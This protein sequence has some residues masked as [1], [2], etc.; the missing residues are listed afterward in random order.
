MLFRAQ[1]GNHTYNLSIQETEAEGTLRVHDQPEEH[2]EF[3][4]CQ[5]DSMI[6]CLNN[7]I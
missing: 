1:Y 5:D 4:I 2:K 6:F 7:K 3:Q